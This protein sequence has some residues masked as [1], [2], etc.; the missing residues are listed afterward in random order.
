M[1]TRQ[2]GGGGKRGG[3]RKGGSN[4]GP[5][6]PDRRKVSDI[7]GLPSGNQQTDSSI[8]EKSR[9]GHLYFKYAHLNYQK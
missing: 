4:A 9:S 6:I 8:P 2:G 3:D 5:E 1:R 7:P